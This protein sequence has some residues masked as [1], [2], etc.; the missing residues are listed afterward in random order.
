MPIP[1]FCVDFNEM[2][3]DDMVLLSADDTK[4]D[5]SGAIV[6]LHVGMLVNIYMNDLDEHGNADDLVASGVVVRNTHDGWSSHV[7]WCCRIDCNGVR[8]RSMA[9]DM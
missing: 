7:R 4:V 3:D 8:Q 9:G 1:L 2:V 5:E 6:H